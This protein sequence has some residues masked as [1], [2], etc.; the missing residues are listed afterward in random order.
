MGLDERMHV[1]AEVPGRYV[2]ATLRNVILW[3]W[4]GDGTVE[5]M[6][7]LEQVWLKLNVH[8]QRISAIHV[9]RQGVGVPSAPVRKVL[10]RCM[11]T[12]AEQTAVLSVVMLGAGFWASALQSA[13]TGIRM[14]VP[15][16]DSQM[17]FGRDVQSLQ[18]W[19]TQEHE[20]SSGV[21]VDEV[22]LMLSLEQLMSLGNRNV[23]DAA[24]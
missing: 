20:R 14:M 16:R 10:T 24:P 18:G 13:L 23:V 22:L 15:A 21:R 2:A 7:A 6:E 11:E 17:R 3:Y 9:I 8:H 1:V 5:G 19:F 12:Y 4:V